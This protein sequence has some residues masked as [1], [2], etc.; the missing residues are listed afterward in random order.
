MSSSPQ[1]LEELERRS[2]ADPADSALWYRWHQLATRQR[3][4]LEGRSLSDWCRELIRGA[5]AERERADRALA[6]LGPLIIPALEPHLGDRQARQRKRA[7]RLIKERGGLIANAEKLAWIAISDRS[8][9]LASCAEEML[10]ALEPTPRSA[11]SLL[12]QASRFEDDRLRFHALRVLESLGAKAAAL[13]PELI[14]GVEDANPAIRAAKLRL[15]ALLLPP[16][17]A[18]ELLVAALSDPSLFVAE[19]ALAC[20]SR[21]TIPADAELDP[22][23]AAALRAPLDRARLMAACLEYCGPELVHRVII[24]AREARAAPI[25]AALMNQWRSALTNLGALYAEGDEDQ[26]RAVIE[27]ARFIGPSRSA[28]HFFREATRDVRHNPV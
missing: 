7:L 20:L 3:W 5:P 2:R 28:A 15:R 25:L 9:K 24:E 23:L 4:T 16:G 13:I 27:A 18:F 8:H 19:E 14:G 22:I 11:L 6:G 1:S 26:R 21:L 17:Q 12:L 10:L